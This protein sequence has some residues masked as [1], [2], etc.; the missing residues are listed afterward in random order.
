MCAISVKSG[1]GGG[2]F[3][4]GCCSGFRRRFDRCERICTQIEY[5]R[6]IPRLPHKIPPAQAVFLRT[7]VRAIERGKKKGGGKTKGQVLRGFC[8]NGVCWLKVSTRWLG[9]IAA[10]L[11]VLFPI[12]L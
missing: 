5:A 7:E 12:P 1:L 10:S 9:N 6:T 8:M 4:D 2:V 11:L 3:G